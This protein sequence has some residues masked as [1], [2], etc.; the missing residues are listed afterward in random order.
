M[1]ATSLTAAVFGVDAHL[2]RVEA[3]TAAGF[4]RFTMLGLADSAVRESEGRIRAALR[5]CGYGFKWDRRITVSMAPAG[6]RKAGSSYDLAIAVGLLAAD[7]ALADGPLADIL[8]VGELA[9]DGSVRPV[10]GV[11][12]M[13]LMARRMGLRCAAVPAANAAEATLAEGVRVYPVASLPEAATLA[14]ACDR[15][16][17]EPLP[18]PPPTDEARLDLADVRGQATARRALEVAAAGGHNLLL[19]GPPGSG[20]TMLARRLPGLLPPL[21]LDEALET[22]AIHSA[23]GARPATLLRARPFRSPHHTASEAALV[24]GGAIPR[25]GEVS[26]AHNGVLF[27]DELPEFS[28]ASLEALRQPLEDRCVTISR[29]RGSAT[30]P[31]R[32]QLVTAMNPCPCGRRGDRAGACG[33]TP[34]QLERYRHRLSGPLLDRIDVFAEVPALAYA[35]LAG[36]SGEP[37][38]AVAARVTA[39]RGRQEERLPTTGVRTNGDLSGAMARRVAGLLPGAEALLARAVDRLGL[40]GR[41]HDRLLRLARTIADL[42]AADSVTAAHLA[43]AIQLRCGGDAIIQSKNLEQG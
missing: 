19:S 17:P 29:A 21:T 15:P 30:L 8:L 12:P 36:P 6:L 20:K 39:A 7:G 1:L 9:L 34:G 16:P 24:G 26:L 33:C 40:T 41:T 14:G 22:T 25:P 3:D 10:A 32:F 43:E 23:S 18:P 31:A 2:V 5:N 38:E 35:E 28:R 11:L 42:D 27:L 13:V 37:S 4:P